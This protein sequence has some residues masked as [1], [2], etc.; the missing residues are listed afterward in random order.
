MHI[1]VWY[2]HQQHF[3]R[4]FLCQRW[5]NVLGRVHDLV[6]GTSLVCELN[7]AP[8]QAISLGPDGHRLARAGDF[9]VEIDP[10]NLRPGPNKLVLRAE[11]PDR[12]CCLC[13]VTIVWERGRPEALPLAVQWSQATSIQDVAQVVDGRWALTPQGVRTLEPWYDRV[14]GLGDLSWRDYEVR[15]TVT[16]HG[17][18]EPGAGDGGC[19]VIHA[20]LALRWPGHDT[21]ERQPR[22]KWYPLGATAEFRVNPRWRDCRW[23]ILGGA[24]VR[25]ES[26][27]SRTIEL[28]G[29][30]GMK[31]RVVSLADGGARYTA[32]LWPADGP[33]PEAW[34]ISMD[35]PAGGVASGGALLIAH[36]TDV[37]FGDVQIVP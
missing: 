9:N 17:L 31:A 32:K 5:V 24:G 11:A 6:R 23:R 21:D 30:Y 13:E 8:P 15:T 12:Q 3:G 37:T 34:D 20:A 27:R 16:F 4:R 2:G 33:E 18:H 36:Y 7:G 19:G 26:D 22:V 25:V 1:D 35:R 28:G 10:I 29:R 14:I